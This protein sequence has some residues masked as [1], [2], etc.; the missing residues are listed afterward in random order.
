M[1]IDIKE[2]S[3]AGGGKILQVHSRKSPR[4]N[5]QKSGSCLCCDISQSCLR[6]LTALRLINVDK[7]QYKDYKMGGCY[8]AWF[9]IELFCPVSKQ[10]LLMLDRHEALVSRDD[11]NGLSFAAIGRL[12]G[13][14]GG[15]IDQ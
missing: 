9:H 11:D 1:L 2:H 12:R 10:L 14:G 8:L 6:C 3:V 7:L 5:I 13:S 4:S 15:F